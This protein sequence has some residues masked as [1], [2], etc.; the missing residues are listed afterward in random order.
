ML[1]GA[2]PGA[3]LWPAAMIVW[4]QG[5]LP[6]GTPT[7]AFSSCWLCVGHCAF[8]GTPVMSG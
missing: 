5:T 2:A 8:A 4:G 1:I 3:L 6:Q 7:I